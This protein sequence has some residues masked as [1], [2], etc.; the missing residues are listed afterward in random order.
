MLEIVSY[1]RMV[2]YE[3][4]YRYLRW[5]YRMDGSRGDLRIE[6]A[7]DLVW[8]PDTMLLSIQKHVESI[9][10][11]YPYSLDDLS[12]GHDYPPQGKLDIYYQMFY[13]LVNTVRFTLVITDDG[14]YRLYTSIID[15]DDPHIWRF[16][17]MDR[18]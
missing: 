15:Y 5:L 2:T 11:V 14:S 16:Y 13:S 4:L 3:C 10:Y 1:R 18:L 12:Y 7:D 17:R 9:H 8:V 6:V